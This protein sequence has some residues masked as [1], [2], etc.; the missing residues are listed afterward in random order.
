M[1]WTSNCWDNSARV[2]SPFR[3]ARATFALKAGRWF[4][5]GRLLIVAPDPQPSWPPSGRNSTQPRRAD[6]PS[7]LSLDAPVRSLPVVAEQESGQ[8]V[9]ALV[10]GIVCAGIGPFAQGRLDEA[11][12]LAVGFWGV[13]PGAL[14]SDAQATQGLGVAPGFEG[15]PVVG[16]DPLD[17]DAVALE[18]TQGVEQ[19][20]EAG[21]ALLAGADL[22]VGE[23]GVVVDGQMQVL[24]AKVLPAKV[25]PAN[26][27]AR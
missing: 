8:R 22:G 23:P 21:A 25:L 10:G 14:V 12:D 9:A 15:G 7:H 27:A 26:A 24:L 1:G 11:L 19:E 5:W 4:R 20:G 6:F 17:R 13:G 3:A 18:E 16:H 2:F